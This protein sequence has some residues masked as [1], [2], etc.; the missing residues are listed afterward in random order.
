MEGKGSVG[1]RS[2]ALIRKEKHGKE[3]GSVGKK[4]EAWESKGDW[5]EAFLISV[6]NRYVLKCHLP[7]IVD[8]PCFIKLL[9]QSQII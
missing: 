5:F 4:R 6:G 9:S 7:D 3:K 8:L 1:K 2:E